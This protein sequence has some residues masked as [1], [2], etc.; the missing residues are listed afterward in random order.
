MNKK[1]LKYAEKFPAEKFI[2]KDPPP[3]I[4]LKRLSFENELK[5]AERGDQFTIYSPGVS[6]WVRYAL[7]RIQWPYV[8]STG[9]SMPTHASH[10]MKLEKA[11]G[12]SYER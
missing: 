8:F 6:G 3:P 1:Y 10:V 4:K 12:E 5:Q 9:S 7:E 11:N 2:C